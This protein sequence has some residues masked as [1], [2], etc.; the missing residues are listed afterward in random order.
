MGYLIKSIKN[1]YSELIMNSQEILEDMCNYIHISVE[2]GF[3]KERVSEGIYLIYLL[4]KDDKIRNK[5]EN[6][7]KKNHLFIINYIKENFSEEEMKEY[8]MIDAWKIINIPL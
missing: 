2:N 4:I 5:C 1:E 8:E 7:W 6:E 3:N